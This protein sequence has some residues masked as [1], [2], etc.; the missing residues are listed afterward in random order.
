MPREWRY[1]IYWCQQNFEKQKNQNVLANEHIKK[2]VKTYQKR[3]EEEKFSYNASLE[4]VKENDYNLNIP[5]YVDTFEEEEEI[6]LESTSKRLKELDNEIK[7][8][9][10]EIADFCKQLN[11]QTKVRFFHLLFALFC[12]QP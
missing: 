5:R 8:N 12:N 3:I 6:D 1:F 7:D 11:I 9:D 10:Q 2:I 4:E